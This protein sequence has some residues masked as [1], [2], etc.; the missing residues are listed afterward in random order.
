MN[1]STVRAGRLGKV[2]E[3]A[4]FVSAVE[5]TAKELYAQV[6]MEQIRSQLAS[7]RLAKVLCDHEM[8]LDPKLFTKS[9]KWVALEYGVTVD[10]VYALR[11]KIREA[12]HTL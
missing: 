7:K 12:L 8:S 2:L 5:R 11:K 9:A 6:E 1:H 10:R 4:G 3:H